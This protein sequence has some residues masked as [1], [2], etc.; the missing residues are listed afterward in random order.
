MKK[1]APAVVLATGLLLAGCAGSTPPAA[2]PTPSRM[3]VDESCKFLNT[4]TFVPTGNAQQQAE[5]TANHYQETA[6]KVAQEVAAPIQKMA[7]IMRKSASSSLPAPTA[8]RTAQ[9]SEQFNKIGEY[10]K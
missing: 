2:S 5:Q 8:E 1:L 6:D 10:C 4:D 9:L 7:D 3:G